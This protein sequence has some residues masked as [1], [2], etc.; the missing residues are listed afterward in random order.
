MPTNAS[1]IRNPTFNF[2]AGSFWNP[3]T[4]TGAGSPGAA[5]PGVGGASSNYNVNPS[6]R[7]GRGA[8]GAVPGALGLPSPFTD[9]SSVYPNLSGTNAA[10][11]A[12]IMA[13]LR[14]ELS[15]GTVNA[16][17]D[18]AAT[19]G[20][21]SGMLGGG[22]GGFSPD[23][24]YSNDALRRIGMASEAQTQQG[25]QDYASLIPTIS[26][27]QTVRPELQTEIAATNAF[28]GAMPNPSEAASYAQGLF[29]KYLA[30]LS[31]PAGGTGAFSV[32]G[33]GGGSGLKEY[34]KSH[35]PYGGGTP[36]YDYKYFA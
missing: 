9:L 13:K 6:P 23:S 29:D 14:G 1:F 22:G 17:Q 36:I 32:G 7:S 24:L 10:T 31:S 35:I 12:A 20:V 28:T 26:S 16:I 8:F 25:L 34:S 2:N 19:F 15:P 5:S 4:Y 18:A 3:A 21:G 11:S 27:T 30:K 33:G